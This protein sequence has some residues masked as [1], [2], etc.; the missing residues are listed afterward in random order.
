MDLE[1]VARLQIGQRGQPVEHRGI[2]AAAHHLD[3]LAQQGEVAAGGVDRRDRAAQRA[4][5]RHAGRLAALVRQLDLHADLQRGGGRRPCA[6]GIGLDPD[7]C[8]VVLV[9]DAFDDDAAET[10]DAA[11]RHVAAALGRRDHRRVVGI[12]R[13]QTLDLGGDRCRVVAAAAA[14][15]V[16]QQA[17]HQQ[18]QGTEREGPERRRRQERQGRTPQQGGSPT[19][20]R[21]YDADDAIVPTAPRR[22][23]RRRIGGRFRRTQGLSE[24]DRGLPR[25]QRTARVE[26]RMDGRA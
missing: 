25:D 10:G 2:G 9:L 16:Q 8:L 13:A 14:A 18:M 4:A 26:R 20:S 23:S 5:D 7:R 17:Q 15:G 1:P 12:A 11:D 3:L 6:V 19:N 22:L 24:R 21:M